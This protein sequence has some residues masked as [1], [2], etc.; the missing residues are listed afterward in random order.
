[1]VV[2]VHTNRLRFVPHAR[3]DEYQPPSAEEEPDSDPEKEPEPD[4]LMGYE[5]P[6][7]GPSRDA[8]IH[9]P[10]PEVQPGPANP[11]RPIRI[12]LPINAGPVT[13]LPTATGP[14]R[15]RRI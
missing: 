10:D 5:E 13:L 2:K 12:T 1:M 14:E 7:P 11:S 4:A 6:T 8:V 15:H 3:M 9:P